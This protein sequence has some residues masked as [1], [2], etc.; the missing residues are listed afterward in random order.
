MSSAYYQGEK[1]STKRG[2][3][4][5]WVHDTEVK[6]SIKS[7]IFL[8]ELS[9]RQLHN[10]TLALPY[11]VGLIGSIHANKNDVIISEKY[12]C[13]FAPPS[14]TPMTDDHKMMCGCAICKNSKYFQELLNVWQ[15][16]K[17]KII[18]DKAYNLLEKKV[19]LTQA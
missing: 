3:L 1:D 9:I 15:K 8:L 11:Y 12:I 5:D 4:I 19:E 14:L 16:K 6:W 18:K 17:L 7:C 10:K 13:A 2:N